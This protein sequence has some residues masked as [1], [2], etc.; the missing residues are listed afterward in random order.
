[1]MILMTIV[2][3]FRGPGNG[4]KSVIDLEVCETTSWVLL[5]ILCLFSVLF[6]LAALSISSKEHAEKVRVGYN[7][8]RGDVNFEFKTSIKL[9]LA[10][11]F[12]AFAA[13]LSGIG[14][15]LVFIPV[16]LAM[17]VNATVATG[18][19]MYLTMITTLS[20]TINLLIVNKINL[21]YSLVINLVTILA[22]MPGLYGQIWVVKRA[23]GRTQFTV[24]LVLLYIVMPLITILPLQISEAIKVAADGQSIMSFSNYC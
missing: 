1:M 19:G 18:T 8:V 4:I 16:V 2:Q 20:A 5:A 21:T 9:V 7:F 14:P 12:G 17:D 22:S 15:G 6:T 24:F 13:A 10:A 23:G 11:F 3:L